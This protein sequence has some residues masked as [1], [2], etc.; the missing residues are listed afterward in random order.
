MRGT[1]F[2]LFII[3]FELVA[4]T[5]FTLPTQ[6]E[7]ESLKQTTVLSNAQ[8]KEL[9]EMRL[10]ESYHSMESRSEGRLRWEEM[11]HWANPIFE[12]K[13]NYEIIE[14]AYAKN[15]NNEQLKIYLGI[16]LKDGLKQI[17]RMKILR[18][19]LNQEILQVEEMNPN[20]VR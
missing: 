4:C 7:S 16:N 18:Y 12:G 14:F 10:P 9:L 19:Y 15:S 13:R 1:T 3:Y 6:I 11:L 20:M 8:I 5:Q 2:L 17:V